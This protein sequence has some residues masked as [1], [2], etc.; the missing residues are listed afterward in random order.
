MEFYV[1][2]IKIG[3]L[4]FVGYVKRSILLVNLQILAIILILHHN[5]IHAY[6]RNCHTNARML[7]TINKALKTLLIST[8]QSLRDAQ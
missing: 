1:L 8:K 2:S 7:C 4:L 6:T 5:S 3:I